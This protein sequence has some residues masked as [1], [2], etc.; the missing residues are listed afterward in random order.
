VLLCE[1]AQTIATKRAAANPM[2]G[3]FALPPFARFARLYG[4]EHHLARRDSRP[5]LATLGRLGSERNAPRLREHPV[6]RGK[7]WGP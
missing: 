2:V 7:P 3:A 5:V 1:P 4:V 6:L